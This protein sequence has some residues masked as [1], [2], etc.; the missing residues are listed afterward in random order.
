MGLGPRLLL[1][2]LVASVLVLDPVALLLR[3]NIN[4]DAGH[5]R[6]PHKGPRLRKGVMGR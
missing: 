1:A 4:R 3:L 2:L 5:M 6:Y